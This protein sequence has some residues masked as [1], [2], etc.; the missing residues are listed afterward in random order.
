MQNNLGY[1]VVQHI[2]I[3]DFLNENDGKYLFDFIFHLIMAVSIILIVYVEFL[4]IYNTITNKWEIIIKNFSP[5]FIGIT[6]GKAS[7]FIK[8][9][10]NIV[11]HLF[12]LLL[13]IAF[14]FNFESIDLIKPFLRISSIRITSLYCIIPLVLLVK[15][16]FTINEAKEKA[17]NLEKTE[18]CNKKG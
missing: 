14:V 15:L 2:H 6:S 9:I 12:T 18:K 5:Y 3:F 1:S 10:F 11:Y 13:L 16:A 7:I 17:D 8:E 4:I